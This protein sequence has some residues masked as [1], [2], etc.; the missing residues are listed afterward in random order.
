MPVGTADVVVDGADVAVDGAG[1]SVDGVVPED[2]TGV[3]A[4]VAP[5]DAI[6]SGFGGLQDMTTRATA[7]IALDI[8]STGTGT[9]EAVEDARDRRTRRHDERSTPRVAFSTLRGWRR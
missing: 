6:T 7:T 2:A 9:S 1:L 8:G 3:G 4:R 5:R